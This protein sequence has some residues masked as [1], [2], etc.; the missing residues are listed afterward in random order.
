[1]AP[2][3]LLNPLIDIKRRAKR[4]EDGQELPVLVTRTSKSDWMI[5]PDWADRLAWAGLLPLAR[6][7]EA[8]R[9]ERVRV[10]ALEVGDEYLDEYREKSKHF[11]YDKSLLTC[12]VD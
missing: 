12:L 1:M 8:T 11:G 10:P 3:P 7:V 5:H 6:M 9:E 4:T 2:Y